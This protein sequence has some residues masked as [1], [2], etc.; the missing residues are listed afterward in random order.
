MKVFVSKATP[1][2]ETA[3][4]LRELRKVLYMVPENVLS[5]SLRT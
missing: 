2:I 5:I 4:S 3:L 1:Y